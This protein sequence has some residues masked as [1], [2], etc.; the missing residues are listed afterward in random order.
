MGLLSLGQ[1][2]PQQ[3][4]SNKDKNNNIISSTKRP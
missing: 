2:K 1:N 3:Q 4:G